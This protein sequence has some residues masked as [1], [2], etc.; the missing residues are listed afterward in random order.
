MQRREFTRAL[1]LIAISPLLAPYL[2]SAR[3]PETM[4][5]YQGLP[6]QLPDNIKKLIATVMA[7]DY[8]KVNT[9]WF[10]SIQIEGLLRFA[11]RGH[12]EGYDY[13][14]NWFNYHVEHD[15]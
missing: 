9:D 11:K 5:G 1:S 10:G 14:L 7:A 6:P 13:A 3:A 4:P 15:K 2:A 8:K 12:R